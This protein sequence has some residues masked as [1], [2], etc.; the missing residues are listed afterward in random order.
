MSA[1]DIHFF[2]HLR[3]QIKLYHW[4]TR[5][6]ARHIATDKA[7]EDLDKLIDQYVEV[8][9]GKY[10]RPKVNTVTGRIHLVNMSEAGATRFVRASLRYLDTVLIKHLKENDTDLINIRDELKS[11]LNQLLYLFTLH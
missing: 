4:Q 1:E 11:N 3:N 2:M 8:Y 9:I 6:Y 5:V 10:G 7:V